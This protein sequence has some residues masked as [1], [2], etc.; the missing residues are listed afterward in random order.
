VTWVTQTRVRLKEG[1]SAHVAERV[2]LFYILHFFLFPIQM[3]KPNQIFVL[4]FRFPI[5]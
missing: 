1:N 2:S 4:N 5:N 3:F